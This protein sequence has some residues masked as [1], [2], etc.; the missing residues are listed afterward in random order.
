MMLWPFLVVFPPYST[1]SRSFLL[2]KLSTWRH[3]QQKDMSMEDEVDD[4][5]E[6]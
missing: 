1:S 2:G 5:L 4:E 3:V 6:L